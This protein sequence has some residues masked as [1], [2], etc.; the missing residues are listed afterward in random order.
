MQLEDQWN[1]HK[2][3]RDKRLVDDSRRKKQEQAEIEENIRTRQEI[4]A[5]QRSRQ[6][7]EWSTVV[8]FCVLLDCV[9]L[10]EWVRGWGQAIQYRS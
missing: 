10:G 2:R 4:V 7:C 8:Y 1:R 6:L 9:N 3:I 5:D